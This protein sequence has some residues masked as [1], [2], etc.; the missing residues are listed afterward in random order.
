MSIE[1]SEDEFVDDF[2]TDLHVLDSADQ[3]VEGSTT[4][5]GVDVPAPSSLC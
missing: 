3:G 4:G 1:K 5:G 2:T